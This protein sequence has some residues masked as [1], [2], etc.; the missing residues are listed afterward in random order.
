VIVRYDSAEAADAHSDE[1]VGTGVVI[2]PRPDMIGGVKFVRP[3]MAGT[4]TRPGNRAVPASVH[5]VE[6]VSSLDR[7]WLPGPGA[8]AFSRVSAGLL[9][10][11]VRLEPPARGVWH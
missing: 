10:V 4:H 2:P 6:A 3:R 9:V 7:Q 11:T 1:K 5:T 8:V